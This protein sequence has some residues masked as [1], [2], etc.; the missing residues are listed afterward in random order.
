MSPSL[1]PN[2]NLTQLKHQAKDLLKAHQRGDLTRCSI[3]GQLRQF[4]GAS[5]EDVLGAVVKLDDAQ[6]ALAMHYGFK[7]WAAMKKYVEA[8]GVSPADTQPE[9]PDNGKVI[10]GLEEVDLGGSFTKPL[11]SF[12]AAAA[13]ILRAQG[14][15]V[16]YEDVMGYNGFAFN[17][18]L[19]SDNT[20]PWRTLMGIDIFSVAAL[21][22]GFDAR[23]WYPHF[24]RLHKDLREETAWPERLAESIDEGLG[25]MAMYGSSGQWHLICGYRDGGRTWI[26]LPYPGRQ[27]YKELTPNPNGRQFGL[28]LEV[29][30]KTSEVPPRRQAIVQSLGGAVDMSRPQVSDQ[31][32]GKR[33]WGRATYSGWIEGLRY[34]EREW[35]AELRRRNAAAYFDLMSRRGTAASYLRGIADGLGPATGHLRTAASSYQKIADRLDTNQAVTTYPFEEVWTSQHRERQADLLEQCLADE[36]EAVAE[37]ERALALLE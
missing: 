17:G 1:P 13:A 36:N 37:I 23:N 27:E 16:T 12:S 7:S 22:F 6:F 20:S 9:S 35:T 11:D 34:Y 5:G 2:A 4:A 30:R 25:A 21:Y 18:G 3:L 26:T 15:T 19:D 29:F 10:A 24:P 28:L 14:M 31:G 32:N 33:V 8:L